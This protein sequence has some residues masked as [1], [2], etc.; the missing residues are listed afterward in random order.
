MNKIIVN[1]NDPTLWPDILTLYQ[2]IVDNLGLPAF[3]EWLRI[4]Y[5]WLEEASTPLIRVWW[6]LQ[7]KHD[8]VMG[9]EHRGL[10]IVYP[11]PAPLADIARVLSGQGEAVRGEG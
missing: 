5:P 9:I 11:D 8:E 3:V 1:R 6:I 10:F 7:R 2:A 4:E